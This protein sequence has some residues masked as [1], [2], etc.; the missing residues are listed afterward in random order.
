MNMAPPVRPRVVAI[1]QP[2]FFPWLGYFNKVAYA[3]SVIVLDSVPIS[4][5]GGTWLNRVRV[6]LNGRVSWVTMPI[7]RGYHGAQLIRHVQIDGVAWRGRLLRTLQSAYGRAPH[8][9]KVYPLVATLVNNQTD[10]LADFNLSAIR[11]LTGSIGLDPAKFVVGSALGVRGR[12]NELL[13]EMVRAVGGTVYLCG[14]GAAGYQEDQTFL[15]AGIDLVHQGFRHPV[16][17]QRGAPE[18]KEGLSIID[19]LMNCGFEATRDMVL[20]SRPSIVASCVG[21]ADS[22]GRLPPRRT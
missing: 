2:T 11:A 22:M 21:E 9:E 18:F 20:S 16:Y 6:L 12:G 13:V 3:D 14:D 4:K 7:V 17:G 10:S 1:H 5:T 15:G 8:F 19:T